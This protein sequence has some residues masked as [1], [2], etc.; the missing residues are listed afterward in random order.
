MTSNDEKTEKIS[1]IITNPAD[2]LH[3]T[4]ANEFWLSHNMIFCIEQDSIRFEKFKEFAIY[5][6]NN[7]YLGRYRVVDKHSFKAKNISNL[8]SLMAFGENKQYA[9]SHL[10]KKRFKGRLSDSSYFALV[11][12]TW[13]G[14]DQRN[15]IKSRNNHKISLKEGSEIPV[16]KQG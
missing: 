12:L 5:W 1:R 11:C 13:I 7:Q 3:F 16:Q 8:L 2:S 10:R 6:K 15:E 4:D 9:F 14:Y